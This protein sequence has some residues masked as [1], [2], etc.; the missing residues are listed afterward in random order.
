MNTNSKV[1]IDWNRT[2][3]PVRGENARGLN[4]DPRLAASDTP[5]NLG[6]FFFL[7]IFRWVSDFLGEKKNRSPDYEKIDAAG[8]RIV[9]PGSDYILC[10]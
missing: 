10:N 4:D 5:R 3:T 6:L 2:F 9:T 1:V 7:S 8:C